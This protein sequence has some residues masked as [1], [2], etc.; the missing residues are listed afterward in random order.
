MEI[1]MS[2]LTPA[3]PM[4]TCSSAAIDCVRAYRAE[5]RSS[6]VITFIVGVD[7]MVYQKDLGKKTELLAKGMTEYNPDSS[8]QRTKEQA[9]MGC[10]PESQN[11]APSAKT[12]GAQSTLISARLSSNRIPAAA[13]AMRVLPEP[14]GPRKSR[15]PTGRPGE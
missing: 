5:F 11:G 9:A 4:S 10:R 13:S 14:V 15:F 3:P 6:G 2:D 8:W 1:L 7:G 12:S